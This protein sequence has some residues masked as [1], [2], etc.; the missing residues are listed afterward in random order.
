MAIGSF[1]SLSNAAQGRMAPRV[2]TPPAPV[3]EPYNGGVSGGQ[4]A[5]ALAQAK[6]SNGA[7]LVNFNRG[8]G[9]LSSGGKY[10]GYFSAGDQQSAIE[11]SAINLKE[12]AGTYREKAQ[13]YMNKL[14]PM[15]S[16]ASKGPARYFQ[17]QR[18]GYNSSQM[19]G[20]DP[21]RPVTPGGY[22]DKIVNPSRKY[23]NQLNDW[24]TE[25]STPA[26]KY[27]AAAEQIDRTPISKY[28]EQIATSSYGMNPDLARGKFV[29]LDETYYKEQQNLKSLR[30]NGMPYEQFKAQ[31]ED[32]LYGTS[33]KKI[34]SGDENFASTELDKI[35]G[36]GSKY[37]S[38]TTGQTATQMYGAV[39]TKF[40]FKD[41]E[42]GQE[43]DTTGNYM[44]QQYGVYIDEGKMDAANQLLNAV[45]KDR[46]DLARLMKGLQS[47]KLQKMGKAA[48]GTMTYESFLADLNNP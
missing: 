20:V 12:S 41:P 6:L 31:Q 44:L 10:S 15:Y 27:N 26:L 13:A 8:T 35:S 7:G 47:V 37:L 40:K 29:G 48:I 39:N 9:G 32:D 16:E 19:P 4:Q 18:G 11:G 46:Q 38:A 3:L 22:V 21:R 30:E 2:I 45:P 42:D 43:K 24:Y 34:K 28:A 17:A 14:D 25:Q 36:V 33:A 23:A 5:N 1:E